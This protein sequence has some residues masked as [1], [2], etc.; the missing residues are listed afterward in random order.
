MSDTSFWD[1]RRGRIFSSK[2]G[3]RIGEGIFSHGFNMMEDFVG[4]ISYMQLVVLNATGRLPERRLADWVEA[5]YI[6]LSWPDP[7][8]WCNAMG[9]LGGSFRTTALAA[10]SA[11]LLAMDSRIYGAKTL[12][13]G[14]TFVQRA[15]IDKKNGSSTFDII[16]A[17]CNQHNG[18]P[19]IMGYARPIAKGDERICA[20]ERVAKKLEFEVG[21]HLK[22][23]YEIDAMLDENYNE[24][25][26]I[27]GYV[28]AFLSDQGF[29]P[30]EVYRLFSTLVASGVTACYVE[31]VGKLPGSF[32]PLRCEDI[33]YR[34][35]RQRSVP[36]R[37]RK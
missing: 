14:V 5:V 7:R 29:T 1:D 15:L 17:E 18:K 22:L 19:S 4:T 8:I 11:G 20:M 26:N 2:G 24:S 33:E 31:E 6:C 9:A 10:T 25:M 34:G 12:I 27:N 21:E 35:P 13:E 37:G 3:W 16:N 23:A 30:D 36:I 32:T 28:S